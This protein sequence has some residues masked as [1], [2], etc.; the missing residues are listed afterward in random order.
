M[1]CFSP[2]SAYQT[3]AGEIVFAERGKI[4]RHLTLPCGQC[5]GCRLERSRQWAVRCMHESQLHEHNS[6]VTLTYADDKLPRHGGLVYRDFQL[7]MKR[8][9]KRRTSKVRFFMAGEYGEL[10]QRPHYHACLF[11]AWFPDRQPLKSLPSGSMI[12]RSKELEDLWPDGYSSVGDVTFESAA[13]VARY[14]MKKITGPAAESHY[15]R[16]D[17]ETG[18]LVSVSPEFCR[19]SLRKGIGAGWIERYASDVWPHDYVVAAGN[20]MKVP[21]YYAEFLSSQNPFLAEALE[22]DR[23]QRSLACAEDS[24][25]ARLAVREQVTKARLQFKKRGFEH[26]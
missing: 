26:G 25:P 9:R 16:L 1:A 14:V 15:R 4:R 24:S 7:F 21:R 8:L 18:E 10:Y 17:P 5:I 23:Y 19:M 6:F 12:Y 13:Y 22:A 20:K 2:L 11:G 3:E